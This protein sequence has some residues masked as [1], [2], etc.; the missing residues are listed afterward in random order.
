MVKNLLINLLD[1]DL[2]GLIAVASAETVEVEVEE[3]DLRLLRELI[4]L[5]DVFSRDA[6]LTWSVVSEQVDDLARPVGV[7]Y[8]LEM[9]SER[10]LSHL[11]IP[12]QEN[13]LSQAALLPEDGHR[14]PNLHMADE[15]TARYDHDLLSLA[16]VRH[17]AHVVD[18]SR[19]VSC[20]CAVPHSTRNQREL[21][22][23]SVQRAGCLRKVALDERREPAT[24][25]L[26][27][28]EVAIERQI[29]KVLMI[30]RNQ[31]QW[32]RALL[33]H[34]SQSTLPRRSQII[35]I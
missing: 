13:I 35:T 1:H 27:P 29:P 10:L 26:L 2:E 20:A 12:S 7:Q 15:E 5:A 11:G 8:V 24:V 30:A 14:S 16:E 3:L 23:D 21:G 25:D 19:V 17:I 28:D 33:L 18:A 31:L 22:L 4:H 34:P 32:I 6:H 9:K